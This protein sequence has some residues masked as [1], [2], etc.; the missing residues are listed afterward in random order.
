MT[1]PT[2]KLAFSDLGSYSITRQF[3]VNNLNFITYSLRRGQSPERQQPIIKPT[4]LFYV[5]A[6]EIWCFALLWKNGGRRGTF[7]GCFYHGSTNNRVDRPRNTF[8]PRLFSNKFGEIFSLFYCEVTWFL[9]SLECFESQSPFSF[10]KM[11]TSVTQQAIPTHP[12][13]KGY[14]INV[15]IWSTAHLLLPQPVRCCWVRGG[16]GAQLQITLAYVACLC[17]V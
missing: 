6:F 14:R 12:S 9:F 16:V 7:A 15:G 17:Y 1:F 13:Q 10:P 11:K 3:L 4:W 5:K 2:I 8:Y